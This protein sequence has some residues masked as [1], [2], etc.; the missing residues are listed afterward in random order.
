VIRARAF[1]VTV[2]ATLLLWSQIAFFSRE[3]IHTLPSSWRFWDDTTLG[4]ARYVDATSPGPAME[5]E[6]G[7][8]APLVQIYRELLE[9]KVRTFEIEP[10]QFWRTVN[11]QKFRTRRAPYAAPAFEDPG[12]G[13]LLSLGFRLVRGVAPYLLLWLGAIAFIPVLA[14]VIFEMVGAGFGVAASALGLLL[15]LSP[16]FYESLALPHSA[17]AFYLVALV[18]VA[19]FAVAALSRGRGRELP[20]KALAK[21]AAFLAPIL[22]VALWCRSGTVF[23]VPAAF[24]VA[25][26]GFRRGGLPRFPATAL[27]ATMILL[28]TVALRPH[29]THNVWLSLWEGL[30][31]FGADRGYSWYDVD[32]NSFLASQGVSGFADP[33]DVN[34]THEAAFRKAFL[35]GVLNSPGWYAGVLAQRLWATVGLTKLAPWGPR[36]GESRSAPL[37]HYKYTMSVD[38]FGWKDRLYEVPVSAL[39]VPTL[40]L[41]VW[42][43]LDRRRPG[44]EVAVL[45]SVGAAALP[46]PLLVSTASGLETQAFGFV[47]FL[48]AAFLLQR[49]TATLPHS[50]PASK[51]SRLSRA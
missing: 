42:S 4:I 31:D 47:Y 9:E 43:A 16:F 37:F 30:G 39:Y 44:G 35:S 25:A 12:R 21:R 7:E 38:W 5:R 32:A 1:A 18:A 20:W 29:Q 22:V 50:L 13:L 28:P 36:D 2:I 26:I 40:A 10:H 6:S 51:R 48:G 8:L 27:A 14:W 34:A 45:A 41:L 15:G 23:L 11:D 46:C 49:V 3:G 33:K 24:L 19:A 17:I